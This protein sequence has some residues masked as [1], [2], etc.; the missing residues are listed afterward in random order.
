ML[1]HVREHA[2]EHVAAGELLMHAFA[3]IPDHRKAVRHVVADVRNLPL[4]WKLYVNRGNIRDAITNRQIDYRALVL[5]VH[6]RGHRKVHVLPRIPVFVQCLGYHSRR[7]QETAPEGKGVGRAVKF[8]YNDRL[9]RLASAENNA[10]RRK[11]ENAIGADARAFQL[12]LDGLGSRRGELHI[13]QACP[14]IRFRLVESAGVRERDHQ[15]RLVE[16]FHLEREFGPVLLVAHVLVAELDRAGVRA[17]NLEHVNKLNVVNRSRN[18]MRR[19]V[20]V[21]IGKRPHRRH[22]IRQVGLHILRLK[23]EYL[24]QPDRCLTGKSTA[25]HG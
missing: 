23:R 13:E 14:A 3:R 12:N 25:I 19:R 4:D 9:L 20:S 1:E 11:V 10:V 7:D 2:L 15:R 16:H 18:R 21:W 24:V 17:C 6:L 8:V 5:H 22:L